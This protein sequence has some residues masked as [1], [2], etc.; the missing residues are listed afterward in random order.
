MLLHW[1]ISF[2][3]YP[4]LLLPVTFIAFC[5]FSLL[6]YFP[7][8]PPFFLPFSYLLSLPVPVSLSP[9]LSR[10]RHNGVMWR[11]VTRV[12]NYALT[13]EKRRLRD[14]LVFLYRYDVID[15]LYGHLSCLAADVCT[16]EPLIS[17]GQ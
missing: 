12:D 15:S 9:L 14:S 16:N 7:L 1:I 17:C 3:T 8:S 10:K 6:S 5:F 11:L 13:A 2:K 4:S